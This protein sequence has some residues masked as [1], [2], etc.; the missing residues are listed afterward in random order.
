MH[1]EIPE[2]GRGLQTELAR[3]TG[4][5]QE[6]VR[7][8]L[9]GEAQPRRATM[10]ELAKIL[11]VDHSWLAI[12]T[13]DVD[14]DNIKKI[15]KK[16][17]SAVHALISFLMSKGYNVA[18]PQDEDYADIQAIGHGVQRSLVVK[19]PERVDETGCVLCCAIPSAPLSLIAA[20]PIDIKHS[21]VYDFLRIESSLFEEEEAQ[22]QFYGAKREIDIK[23]NTLD[24]TYRVDGKPIERFLES[25]R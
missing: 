14:S 15:A 7:K 9:M 20:M 8:W 5:S 3:R 6:A 25:D 10:I 17:G 2:Y 4:V 16:T 1:P 18:F 12:G 19:V 23:F 24:K 21:L 22:D 13:T 11:E